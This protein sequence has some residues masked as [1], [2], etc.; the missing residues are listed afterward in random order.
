[1]N[2][3]GQGNPIRTIT[4]SEQM[5]WETE[6]SKARIHDTSGK[7]MAQNQ[8]INLIKNVI[9]PVGVGNQT[10][11][12]LPKFSNNYQVHSALLDEDYLL[13]GNYVDDNTK[14]RIASG[15]YVDFAKLLPKERG[16]EEDN[17]MELINRGACPI[18]SRSRKERLFRSTI[19]QGG[20]KHS[21]FSA[22][23]T[24]HTILPGQVN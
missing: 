4:R 24:Q 3:T 19:T 22:T 10:P 6:T 12:N 2:R 13:V 16:S 8:G 17:R 9:L 14:R 21:V 15:E 20:N 1:M 18:G 23:F 5:V 11:E 7:D